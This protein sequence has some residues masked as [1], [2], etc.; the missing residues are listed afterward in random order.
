M[1]NKNKKILH[2]NLKKEY[3]EDIKNGNKLF[4]FREYNE[5]WTKRLENKEYDEV[6]FKLGYPK[7]DDE[8]KIIIRKYLGYEFRDIRHKHFGNDNPS[9]KQIKVFA[10]FTNGFL[11]AN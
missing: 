8:E 4:E 1:S 9:C 6:H 5:Y 3:F 2:L 11:D 10:I 7:K